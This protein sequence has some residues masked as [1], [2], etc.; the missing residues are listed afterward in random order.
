MISG[1]RSETDENCTFLGYYAAS[2]GN[3]LTTFRDEWNGGHGLDWS[4]SAQ[5]QLASGCKRGNE[6]SGSI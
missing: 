2:C 4:S 1:F 3:S 5:G 6:T